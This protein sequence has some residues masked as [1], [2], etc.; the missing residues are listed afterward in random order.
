MSVQQNQS[1]NP[2][3]PGSN[4]GGPTPKS[5]TARRRPLPARDRVPSQAV[6]SKRSFAAVGSVQVEAEARGVTLLEA[7]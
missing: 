3:V 7:E 6:S 5:R 1:H 2:L 4:P